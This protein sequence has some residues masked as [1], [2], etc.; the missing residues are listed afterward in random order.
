MGSIFWW[1]SAPGQIA[2]E[3]WQRFLDSYSS[4][5]VLVLLLTIGLVIWAYRFSARRRKIHSESDVFRSYTPMRAI[6]LVFF[7]AAI[8][9]MA[10]VV[11]YHVMLQTWDGL[12]SFAMLMFLLTALVCS[13]IS[14]L[15]IIFI[16]PLTPS[17]FRYRPAPHLHDKRPTR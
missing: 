6:W 17:R 12:I 16:G 9:A 11:Q 14:Y 8:A 2:D 7:G 3:D 5:F 10:A 1:M 13:L 4:V 15:S